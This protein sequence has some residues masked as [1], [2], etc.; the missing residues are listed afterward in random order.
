MMILL[1][2]LAS[3]NAKQKFKS[4][5]IKNPLKGFFIAKISNKIFLGKFFSYSRENLITNICNK[6]YLKNKQKILQNIFFQVY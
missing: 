4:H 3:W 5:K 2:F 6:N 1:N